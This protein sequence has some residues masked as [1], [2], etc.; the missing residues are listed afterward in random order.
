MPLFG[1]KTSV[2]SQQWSDICMAGDGIKGPTLPSAGIHA[3]GIRMVFNSTSD[4]WCWGQCAVEGPAFAGILIAV[5]IL[6]PCLLCCALRLLC[7]RV[8]TRKPAGMV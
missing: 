6:V 1:D 8:C 3:G 2:A 7:P 5:C 4:S